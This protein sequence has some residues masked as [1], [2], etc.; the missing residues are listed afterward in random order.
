[1]KL[2]A[3]KRLTGFFGA[4]AVLLLASGPARVG[5]ADMGFAYS[6]SFAYRFTKAGE[7]VRFAVTLPYV[8]RNLE[9]FLGQHAQN[10]HLT[11]T[12]LTNS[13]QG[14]PVDLLQVG[15][16]ATGRKSVLLTARHH[17]C[18]TMASLV[19]EG[20]LKAA[21]SDTP[22]G[23]AFRSS[24]VLYCVP[25]VDKDG[26]E[27]GDQGKGRYPHDHNRDYGAV[28]I[29]PEVNAIQKLGDAKNIQMLLDLHCPTLRGESHQVMYFDG[30]LQAPANNLLNVQRLAALITAAMPPRAPGGPMVW[31]SNTTPETCCSKYFSTR[32]GAIL[33]TTLEMPYAPPGVL[34]DAA[35]VRTYG[36]AVLRAWVQTTFVP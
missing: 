1:M 8:Q 32:S 21:L 34:M 16:P 36:E 29:F 3:F 26:V 23:A 2:M 31:L 10:P 24:Y 4:L 13:L 5:A 30:P 25:I 14:R 19:L 33:S 9:A 11:R 22:E 17:A 7:K 12:V 6:D 18:E 35:T 15:E 27:A 20:F 28:N